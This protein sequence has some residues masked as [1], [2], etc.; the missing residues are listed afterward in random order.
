MS[1]IYPD[2][3][4]FLDLYYGGP[5]ADWHYG[6]ELFRKHA[7]SDN[8]H[9]YIG[10]VKR[11]RGGGINWRIT[12]DGSEVL[13]GAARSQVSAELAVIRNINNLLP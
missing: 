12:R 5:V 7:S 1:E 2:N 9:E 4:P 10:V 11:V 8:G 13:C 6:E 3:P